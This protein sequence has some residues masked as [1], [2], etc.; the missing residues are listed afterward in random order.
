[1]AKKHFVAYFSGPDACDYTMGC[2]KALQSLKATTLEDAKKEVGE[3]LESMGLSDENS[4]A[5]IEKVVIYEIATETLFNIDAWLTQKEESRERDEEELNENE[6]RALLQ[7]LKNKY[8]KT[9]IG[10]PLSKKD[11]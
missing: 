8:E 11:Q 6:E 1:M 7:K 5:S 3:E 4:T 10:K 9:L 2:N